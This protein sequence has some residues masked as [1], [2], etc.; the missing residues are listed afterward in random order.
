MRSYSDVVECYYVS[1]DVALSI[2]AGQA[3][4]GLRSDT[5]PT[6][7]ATKVLLLGAGHIGETIAR[8]LSETGDYR[9]AVVDESAQSLQ[10]LAG[11]DVARRALPLLRPHQRRARHAQHPRTGG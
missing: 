10:R 11:L 8:L 9:V 2:G 7:T 4:D 1:M 3:S 6:E 5:A